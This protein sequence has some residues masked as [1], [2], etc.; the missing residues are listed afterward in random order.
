MI[1]GALSNRMELALWILAIGPNITVVHRI[2]YTWK[3]TGA[4]LPAGA[5]TSGIVSAP[6]PPAS[7]MQEAHV[8]TRTAGRGA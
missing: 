7:E 3:R 2:I 6:L 8:L 1:L 5:Q 4:A